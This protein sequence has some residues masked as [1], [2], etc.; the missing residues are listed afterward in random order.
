MTAL[1][2]TSMCEL[3]SRVSDGIKVALMWS[4]EDDRLWVAVTD[5]RRGESFQLPVAEGERAMD[6]FHHPYAYAAHH[7]VIA[8]ATIES[9]AVRVRHGVAVC[10]AEPS[11]V[12]A[13]DA[14]ATPA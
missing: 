13:T 3:N 11:A 14:D 2:S 9:E 7:G 1:T 10:R 8:Q 6:V 4:R 5:G 12:C